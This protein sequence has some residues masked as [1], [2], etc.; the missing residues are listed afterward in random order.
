MYSNDK[1]TVLNGHLVAWQCEQFI[2]IFNHTTFTSMFCITCDCIIG[3]QSLFEL[4][5]MQCSVR[6]LHAEYVQGVQEPRSL[7]SPVQEEYISNS[8]LADLLT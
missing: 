6:G 7:N 8:A 5:Q 4:I 2:I 3:K 1:Y